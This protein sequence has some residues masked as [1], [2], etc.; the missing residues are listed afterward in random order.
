MT[1]LASNAAMVSAEQEQATSPWSSAPRAL[2]GGMN[3]E[4]PSD[5][6]HHRYLF[7]FDLDENT[8][9]VH[10]TLKNENRITRALAKTNHALCVSRLRS[11]RL[12]RGNSC[13]SR[14]N[15]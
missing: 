6:C 4:Q 12:A 9:E 7:R 10:A 2:P 3:L 5:V 13:N 1:Q 14:P 11:D 8:P 15:S